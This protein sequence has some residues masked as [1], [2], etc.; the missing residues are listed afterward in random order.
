MQQYIIN[1]FKRTSDEAIFS[2]AETGTNSGGYVNGTEVKRLKDFIC[3]GNF[4]IQSVKRQ[5]DN[6]I[7]TVGDAIN[8]PTEN[9]SVN[10]TSI[11]I[12]LSEVYLYFGTSSVVL[13]GARKYVA[14]VVRTTLGTTTTTRRVGR[15]SNAEI[16][17]RNNGVSAF[18][19]VEAT[20][21]ERNPRA[22]RLERVL[23]NRTESL[24][25]FLIKFF[26]GKGDM[27][28]GW[29]YSRNTIFV[30]DSSVQTDAGRRRSLGDIYMICKYYYPQC[31]LNEVLN[32][33]YIA[34][35]EEITEGFRTS[36]CN[37]IH[38]RVWYYSEGD[39]NAQIDHTDEF[40]NSIEF[41][42]IN[43]Q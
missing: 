15:P 40:G 11:K 12:I 35:P 1:S 9:T 21:I 42:K 4:T 10:I 16:A 28:K 20:I 26:V 31:T 29:N 33:L 5:P 38:K 32:L 17:A 23:K 37:T 19:T 41:Y 22:I 43:I 36:Y 27:E 8:I 39:N 34:I 13:Q 2:L 6:V 25:N 7:F 14:P 30:D 18:A 3:D 24:Q